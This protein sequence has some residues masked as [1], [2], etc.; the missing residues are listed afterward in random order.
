MQSDLERELN[1]INNRLSFFQKELIKIA[2]SWDA[3]DNNS[4][5]K[6]Q[7]YYRPLINEYKKQIKQYSELRK[8]SIKFYGDKK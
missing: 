2:E 4:R 3:W 5:G 1:Y 6:L 8:V 7:K